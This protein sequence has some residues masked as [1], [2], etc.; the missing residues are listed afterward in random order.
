MRGRQVDEP[1]QVAYLPIDPRDIGRDYQAVIRVNS[2]SGKGGVAFVLER[3]HGLILPRWMQVELAQV[4]QQ[5]SEKRGGEIDGATIHRLFQ[6]RFVAD[7][8]P[9]RLQGYRLHRDGSMDTIEMRA[10]DR[11]NEAV[12]R[13]SGEGAI[14]AFVDAWQR[15][16]DQCISVVDYSEHAVGAGTGAEAVAYVQLNVD[17][18]RVT[19]AAFDHDTVSASLKAVL[20]ALNRS[21]ALR[22]AA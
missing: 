4:V 20:S 22:S 6:A 17:G 9:V 11:G 1:W 13:G 8:V 7:Q 15:H 3:D 18:Q 12:M 19:G 5:E 10:T 14:S 2:Q 21:Q 16:Y